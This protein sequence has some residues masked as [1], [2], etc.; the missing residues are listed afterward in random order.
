MAATVKPWSRSTCR[1]PGQASSR[2][3]GTWNTVPML[4]RTLRRYSG[5]PQRGETRTASMPRA[6][7]ERKIAPTLVWS[8]MSSSTA[9]RRAPARSSGSGTG[10]GPLHGRHRAAVQVEAGDL[11]EQR[12]GADVD[13][14]VRVLRR[15]RPRGPRAISRRGRTTAAGAPRRGRGGAPGRIRRCTCPRR[16]PG[17]CAGARRSAACSRRPGG[18]RRTQ[19]GGMSLAGHFSGRFGRVHQGRGHLNRLAIMK[20]SATRPRTKIT[21]RRTTGES[22]RPTLEPIT[23]PISELTA[24]SPTTVQSIRPNAKSR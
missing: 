17:A 7:A 20:P 21:P 24:I 8:T 22:R 18:R 6:A 14:D 13:G 4:T 3:H 11:L 15:R 12:G 19:G 1:S 16:V 9:T 10:S 5:S 2:A 23:P